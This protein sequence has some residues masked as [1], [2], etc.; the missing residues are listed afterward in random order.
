MINTFEG[1]PLVDI[2][3]EISC[4]LKNYQKHPPLKILWNLFFQILSLHYIHTPHHA[5]IDHAY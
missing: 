4:I 1:K 3:F 5:S 2:F